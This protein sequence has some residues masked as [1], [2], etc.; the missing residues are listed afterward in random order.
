LQRLGLKIIR[1]DNLKKYAET[2]AV[3]TQL[4]PNELLYKYSNVASKV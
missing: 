2:I 1:P 3:V 4:Y